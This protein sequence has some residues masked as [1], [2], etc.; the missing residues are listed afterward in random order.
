MVHRGPVDQTLNFCFSL[1][2]YIESE[3]C[4]LVLLPIYSRHWI[5]KHDNQ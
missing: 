3:M 1:L 4:I 2:S 5:P